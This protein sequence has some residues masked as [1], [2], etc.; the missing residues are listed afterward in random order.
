MSYGMPVAMENCEQEAL[1]LFVCMD[2][3]LDFLANGIACHIDY[4]ANKI[5]N[6]GL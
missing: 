6:Y 5:P 4:T 2:I 3:I 1:F